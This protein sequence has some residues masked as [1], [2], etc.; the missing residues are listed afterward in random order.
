MADDD[1]DDLRRAVERVLEGRR[2]VQMQKGLIIR[3]RSAGADTRDAERT[4]RTLEPK[5]LR[6]TPRFYQK[7]IAQFYLDGSHRG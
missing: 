6:G 5:A 4:L 3:L 2:I 1:N 7:K